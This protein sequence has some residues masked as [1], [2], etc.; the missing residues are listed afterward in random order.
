MKRTLA[1]VAAGELPVEDL[2]EAYEQLMNSSDSADIAEQLGL[3]RE[4]WTAFGHGVGFGELARWRRDG[5]PDRCVVCGERIDAPRFS[6][7]AQGD[8]TSHHLV[9]VGCLSAKPN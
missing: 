4:E 1:A 3:S 7:L 6:W 5:W 8:E 9:H 2:E